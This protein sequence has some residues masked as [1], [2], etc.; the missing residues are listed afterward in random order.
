MERGRRVAVNVTNYEPGLRL[1]EAHGAV[2]ASSV[3]G[4]V[5]LFEYA[6]RPGTAVRT[7]QPLDVHHLRRSFGRFV[8]LLARD[9]RNSDVV[10][11]V[12]FYMLNFARGYGE[13]STRGYDKADE[14]RLF[15]DVLPALPLLER[16]LFHACFC[17]E[18]NLGILASRL[19]VTSSLVEL[20]VHECYGDFSVCV[21]LQVLK[22][23]PD[24]RM[25]KVA[26]RQ[27]FSSLRYNS[28]LRRLDVSV[29][30]VY[31]DMPVFHADPSSTSALRHLCLNVGRWTV[32]GKSSLAR[33][34][35]TNTVLEE[36]RI[37]YSATGATSAGT[38]RPWLEVLKSH[39]SDDERILAYLHRNERIRNALVQLQDYPVSP[40]VLWPAA[41]EMVSTLPTLLYR[42]VRRGDV[43]ALGGL[44]LAVQQQQQQQQPPQQQRNSNDDTPKKKKKKKK[45]KRSPPDVPLRPSDRVARRRT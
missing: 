16:V 1:L 22:L 24:R 36:L 9:G 28:N 17:C 33:Q 34:L 32:E 40:P 25:D 19:S 37:R 42:F 43:N 26:C 27:I 39:S 23:K 38:H 31:D 20:E 29:E 5:T 18:D 15:G 11:A 7:G 4:E 44:L 21:P 30:E 13:G 8:D 45:K 12:N 3:L 10:W 41:W 2:A 6:D 35:K 14:A